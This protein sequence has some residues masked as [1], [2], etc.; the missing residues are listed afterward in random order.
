MNNPVL[1]VEGRLAPK[2]IFFRK[3]QVKSS[4]SQVM[5]WLFSKFQ[6]SQSH[7]FD[8]TWLGDLPRKSGR[9]YPRYLDVSSA[10][11]V[12]FNDTELYG[13]NELNAS[14]RMTLYSLFRPWPIPLWMNDDILAP[15]TDSAPMKWAWFFNEPA[16]RTLSGIV[17]RSVVVFVSVL[18]G[19]DF[20]IFCYALPDNLC[21]LPTI[22]RC[23]NFCH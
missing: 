3:S 4:K 18:H 11:D 15:N 20:F 21:P 13:Y 1:L 9:R 5:T 17:C 12:R 10:L 7:D 22:L 2:V 8:L 19:L 6:K 14:Y 16:K 23:I